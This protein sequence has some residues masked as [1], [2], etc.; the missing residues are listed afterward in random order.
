M[1]SS[2]TDNNKHNKQNK[3]DKKTQNR[4]IR[5]DKENKA[6]EIR[7]NKSRDDKDKKNQLSILTDTALRR[8][9]HQEGFR[10]NQKENNTVQQKL[11]DWILKT[12][13][14][15]SQYAKHVGRKSVSQQDVG[16]ALSIQGIE[17][18]SELKKFQSQLGGGKECNT[19]NTNDLCEHPDA[20]PFGIVSD[21]ESSTGTCYGGGLRNKQSRK[22]YKKNHKRGKGKLS[23]INRKNNKNIQVNSRGLQGGDPAYAIKH[24]Q[25]NEASPEN[26]SF[27]K[28]ESDNHTFNLVNRATFPLYK[29]DNLFDL[30]GVAVVQGGGDGDGNSNGNG[31]GNGAF[32]QLHQTTTPSNIISKTLKSL[33]V[34][35]WSKDATDLLHQAAEHRLRNIIHQ[36]RK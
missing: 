36:I 22:K 12:G 7:D 31:N 14:I 18:V 29:Y 2:N 16:R 27:C 3:K 28:H 8:I 23:K 30:D 15:S 26:Q 4:K 1:P 25:Y 35:R 6:R 10:F 32:K 33:G 5:E 21:K 34:S 19:G 9:Y 11:S 20:I 13:W 24:V 17:S